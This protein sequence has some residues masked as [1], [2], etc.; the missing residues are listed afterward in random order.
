MAISK[1]GPLRTHLE[2]KKG[3][4]PYGNSGERCFEQLPGFMV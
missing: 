4:L 2:S 1:E 3:N